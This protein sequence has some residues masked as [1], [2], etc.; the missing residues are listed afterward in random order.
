MVPP[1]ICGNSAEDSPENREETKTN[2]RGLGRV[3][4]A[5]EE[6]VDTLTVLQKCSQYR[7]S[8]IRLSSLLFIN[9]FIFR[10]RVKSV[11][12]LGRTSPVV[13]LYT[14]PLAGIWDIHVLT[15]DVN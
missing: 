2:G 7:V 13:R 12:P 11:V 9:H 8:L 4:Q 6:S 10:E 5:L 1:S 15:R 14:D 3:W